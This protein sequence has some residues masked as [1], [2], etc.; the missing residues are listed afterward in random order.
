MLSSSRKGPSILFLTNCT[1]VVAAIDLQRGYPDTTQHGNPSLPLPSSRR[2]KSVLFQAFAN[3]FVSQRN[4]DVAR[5]SF[6]STL[7]NSRDS[8]RPKVRHE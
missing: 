7:T 4:L 1:E 3:V 5:G 2:R 8:Q 6:C